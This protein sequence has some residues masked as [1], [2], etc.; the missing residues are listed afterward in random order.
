MKKTFAVIL[1]M[2][3]LLTIPCAAWA[4]G[5]GTVAVVADNG[6]LIFAAVC[7]VVVAVT[8]VVAFFRR[9]RA[10]QI[11]TLR[12]WLLWAVMQAERFFGAEKGVLKLRWVYDMFAVKFPWLARV[13]SF[14]RFAGLVDEALERMELLLEQHP[15]LEPY[16]TH[17]SL[18]FACAT[19]EMDIKEE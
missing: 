17:Y 6:W 9:P 3:M 5:A 11:D 15:E 13:L 19:E 16:A 14:D 7:C 2:A 12:E 4:D 1:M 10:E 8:V 18:G